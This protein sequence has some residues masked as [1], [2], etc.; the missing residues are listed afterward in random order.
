MFK[1]FF[2]NRPDKLSKREYW[3]KQEFFDLIK[4][5]HEAEKLLSE[6]SGGY[7]G[8]F[9]AAEEFHAALIDKIDDIEFGNQTDLSEL[10]AWFAPTCAWDDFV[11][12]EG[13][14]LGNRIFARL[15]RWRKGNQ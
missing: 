7:S 1:R 8:A 12:E 3:E 6:Y 4:D 11:G 15:D 13:Q 14:G 2:S 10:W 5:L 9:L